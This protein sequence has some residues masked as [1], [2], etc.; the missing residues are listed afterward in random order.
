MC[1]LPGI[2]R[3]RGASTLILEVRT[4]ASGCCVYRK[5]SIEQAGLSEEFGKSGACRNLSEVLRVLARL[6]LP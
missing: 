3:R 1:L 5:W 6:T 4:S 2:G